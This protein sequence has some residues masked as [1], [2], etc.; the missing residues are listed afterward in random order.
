MCA[1]PDASRIFGE[2]R[3]MGQAAEIQGIV[4]AL[5]PVLRVARAAGYGTDPIDDL[6]VA[7]WTSRS[8]GGAALNFTPEEDDACGFVWIEPGEQHEGPLA[9]LAAAVRP[10][11]DRLEAMALGTG[12]AAFELCV[13]HV[14]ERDGTLRL[15]VACAH[16]EG[17]VVVE[18]TG[19]WSWQNR[20]CEPEAAALAIALV[21][22]ALA[23]ADAGTDRE[24]M[25]AFD[26][27][28]PAAPRSGPEIRR[29]PLDLL[30]AG[31][32]TGIERALQ[33][34]LRVDAADADHA[35]R[36]YAA[37]LRGM[38][39]AT[40]RPEFSE[41]RAAS[42]VV[43]PAL[44]EWVVTRVDRHPVR[45]DLDSPPAPLHPIPLSAAE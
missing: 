25:E 12:L 14:P 34:S 40:G 10:A 38:R 37:W 21:M 27:H 2:G 44:P 30:D 3:A 33:P 22:S 7:V 45:L 42:A 23:E 11:L 5:E 8:G 24:A 6:R 9:A 18:A 28:L 36:R 31:R 39:R 13:R 43:S 20:F 15:E 4:A 35:R 41:A 19:T 26:I 17:L 29:R 32:L 16:V 1:A